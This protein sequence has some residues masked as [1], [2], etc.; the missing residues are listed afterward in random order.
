[1]TAYEKFNEIKIEVGDKVIDKQGLQGT[2]VA[3]TNTADNAPHC[4]VT[5]ENGDVREYDFSEN[6]LDYQLFYLIDDQVIGNK[7]NENELLRQLEKVDNQLEKLQKKKR[8]LKKQLW[9]LREV[10]VPDW[11]ERQQSGKKLPDSDD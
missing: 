6:S 7:C 4:V 1:M 5:W 11:K 8:Q 3:C 2:V 10:M 9:R